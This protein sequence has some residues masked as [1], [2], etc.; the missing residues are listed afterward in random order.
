MEESNLVAHARRELTVLGYDQDTIYSFLNVIRA[1]ADMGHSGGS[2]SV[3]IP[4]LNA[5][6]QF[7]NLSPLTNDP[8]EWMHISEDLWGDGEV[9][10]NIRNGSAFSKDGGRTYTLLDD[11]KDMYGNKKVY[12]STVK[13]EPLDRDPE[14]QES[15][16]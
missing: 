10:Q 12:T 9:W 15:L 13:E 3:A 2:A 7:Q 1:F 8:A 5:L 4:T 6:F 14:E 11:P 16:Y